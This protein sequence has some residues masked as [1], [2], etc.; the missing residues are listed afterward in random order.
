[1]KI[2]QKSTILF[3]LTFGISVHSSVHSFTPESLI[4]YVK[5]KDAQGEIKEIYDEVK[6]TFGMVPAPIMQ[7]SVSPELLKN[8]WDLF[9]VTGKNKNFSQKFLAIMRMSIAT[10]DTFSYCAY[11]VEG[12]AMMLKQAF[13]LSDKEI[14]DIQKNPSKA[15]L[16][17]KEK[18]ML[19]FLLTAT[20]TPQTLTKKSFDE[21]RELGWNDKDIFEGLKMATQMVAAIYMVNSLKISVDFGEKK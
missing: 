3:A 4:P 2:L 1:M 5:E 11:C 10:S 21:L 15:K 6:K 9:K 18:K 7:H 20:K 17:P 14:Q 19:S 13:K 12:N 8:H 16:N